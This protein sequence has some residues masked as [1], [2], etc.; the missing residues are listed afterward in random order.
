MFVTE[1]ETGEVHF[2]LLGT[3]G[4]HV[5]AENEK[6][7]AAGLRCRQ[8]LEYENFTSSFGGLREKIELKSVLHMQHDYFSSLNQSNH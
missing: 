6:F 7:T 2:C 8:N 1:Y 5:K 4:F 3:N